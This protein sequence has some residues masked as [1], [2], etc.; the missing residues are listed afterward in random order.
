MRSRNA[1]TSGIAGTEVVVDMRCTMPFTLQ[2]K[3]IRGANA[4]PA[5]TTGSDKKA[6]S[7]K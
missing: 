1:S 7:E 5:T 4:N 2:Y 6:S 3:V